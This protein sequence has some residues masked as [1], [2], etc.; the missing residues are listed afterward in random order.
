M[1][2]TEETSSDQQQQ[3]QPSSAANLLKNA[4][5]MEAMNARIRLLAQKRNDSRRANKADVVEEDRKI[6]NPRH[7]IEEMKKEWELK[8]LEERQ[9]CEEEGVDFERAKAMRTSVEEVRKRDVLLKR[10]KN[11]NKDALITGDYE[12][13]S[14][15]QNERLTRN[16]KPDFNEYKRMKEALGEEQFY[17][18]SNTIADGH[19]YPTTSALDR[20]A[21]TVLDMQ[22]TREK[23]HRRRMFDPDQEVT[24][25]NE[26]NR[27]FNKKL[28]QFYGKYTED[29][30]EDLERGTAL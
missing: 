13:M 5:R 3:Q 8:D 17:P 26:K 23:V 2:D 29:L 21:T 1:S 20:L 7:Q 22:K 27:V 25:I 10:K 18:G 28:D 24:Y 15:R 9:R 4:E 6:K 12:T 11:P 14:L 16:I 30:R 19:H